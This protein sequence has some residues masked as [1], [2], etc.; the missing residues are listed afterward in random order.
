MKGVV[1]KKISKT[2]PEAISSLSVEEIEREENI[3]DNSVRVNVRC[4]AVNFFD[5]L[6][7]VGKYQFKPPLPF[8]PCTEGSGVITEVGQSVTKWKVGQEVMFWSQGAAAEEAIVPENSLLEKPAALSFAEAAGFFVGYSTAHHGLIQ[9]GALKKGETVLITGAG[10]GMGLAAV[11]IAHLMGAFV[12]AAA[13]DDQK[14]EAAKALGANETINYK[15]NDLREEM[16]RITNGKFADVIYEIVGGDIFDR[17]LRCVSPLGGARLLVIGF[18]GG[19]I[20][21]IPANIPLIKGCSIVGVRSGAQLALEPQLKKDLE[22]E[23]MG[24]AT[25][26]RLHPRVHMAL[27]MERSAEVFHSLTD[28]SV[29]GKAVI[30]ITPSPKAKL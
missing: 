1:C 17:C 9:R 22:D 4:A 27:P 10:G 7:L 23:L 12:I 26:G 16:K 24:W 13:S 28:R 14:L 5:L 15:K 3:G 19:R 21:S 20:P 18:A 29:V 11:Q 8:V 30:E 25:E 6:M 2:F